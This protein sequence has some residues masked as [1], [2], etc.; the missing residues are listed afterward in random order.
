MTPLRERDEKLAERMIKNLQP[1]NIEAFYCP[2]AEEAVKKVSSL[3][4]DGNSVTLDGFETICNMGIPDDLRAH[5]TLEVLE[6]DQ[7]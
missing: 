4:D 3:I 7:V 5:A 6:Y 1:R 2:T